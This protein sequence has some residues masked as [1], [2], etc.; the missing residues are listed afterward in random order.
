MKRY[1]LALALLSCRHQE[2]VTAGP[3][4]RLTL[5]EYL[6]ATGANV[7]KELKPK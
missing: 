6:T 5:L 1:L 7:P 2:P 3:D 4:P